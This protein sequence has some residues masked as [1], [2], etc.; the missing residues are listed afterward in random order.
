MWFHCFRTFTWFWLYHTYFPERSQGVMPLMT[1]LGILLLNDYS[2]PWSQIE[3]LQWLLI[4]VWGNN[5]NIHVN[6]Y[7]VFWGWRNKTHWGNQRVSCKGE[8]KLKGT[9]DFNTTVL[10]TNFRETSITNDTHFIIDFS[11]MD[12]FLLN[13][14]RSIT[15]FVSV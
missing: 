14:F 5:V 3:A 1:S 10:R 12:N 4:V 8:N 15:S 9:R 13:N 7:D 6:E 11:I 2:N